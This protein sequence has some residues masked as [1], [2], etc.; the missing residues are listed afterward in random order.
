MGD[1]DGDTQ[2]VH[3]VHNLD[4]EV[5]ETAVV[6]LVLPIADVVLAGVSEARQTDA[7]AVVDVQPVDLVADGQ[8]LQGGQKAN[9]SVLLAR[10]DLV[11]VAHQHRLAAEAQVR[12]HQSHFGLEILEPGKRHVVGIDKPTKGVRRS[13]RGPTAL[14]HRF[15]SPL[16]L[17]APQQF[18]QPFHVLWANKWVLVHVDHYYVFHQALEPQLLFMVKRHRHRRYPPYLSRQRNLIVRHSYFSLILSGFFGY[19]IT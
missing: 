2:R 3:A 7:H 1:V 12:Q 8:V 19:G 6:A 13:D 15:I 4:A 10:L 16:I 14:L 17:V 5:A 9:R 18:H 11:R